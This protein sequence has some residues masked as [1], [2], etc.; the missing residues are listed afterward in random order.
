MG[1]KYLVFKYI[2]N[3]QC[4]RSGDWE[5]LFCMICLILSLETILYAAT[6]T[7][8]LLYNSLGLLCLIFMGL[9]MVS[10][11][12]FLDTIGTKFPILFIASG[13]FTFSLYHTVILYNGDYGIL[14][15]SCLLAAPVFKYLEWKT[16]EIAIQGDI[17]YAKWIRLLLFVVYKVIPGYFL[18]FRYVP[19]GWFSWWCALGYIFWAYFI[20]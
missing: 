15:I 20:H 6:M 19:Y 14:A 9:F 5:L 17:C 10:V 8:L 11:I 3:F 7:D 12:D 2:M 16:K 4:R 1:C 18:H 13:S